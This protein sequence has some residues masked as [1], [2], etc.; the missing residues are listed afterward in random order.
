MNNPRPDSNFLQ[1]VDDGLPM[2]SAGQWAKLKLDVLGYYITLSTRAMKNKLWR[3]RFYIDLQAGPGKNLVEETGEVLLGSPILALT[4]GAG[5]SD[6]RFVEQNK[7]LAEALSKRLQSTGKFSPE[8]LIT[9]N[10]NE[11]VHHI[12]D[13]INRID[14]QYIE[15]RW[16]CLSLA[17]FDPEG[18]ELRWETVSKLAS[19]N[20]VDLIINFSTGGIR[21]YAL[22]ALEAAPGTTEMDRF[23]GNITWRNISSHSHRSIPVREWLDT[24][25]KRLEEIGFIWGTEISVPLKTTY[26]VELYRL[27][28]AS[29]HQ[30]G[31]DLW[32]ESRKRGPEQLSLF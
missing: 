14:T 17:F 28:F 12:V 25:K 5:Y 7:P 11:A 1:P 19:L 21:R 32:E 2:R 10:C 4:K 26:G 20:R 8:S 30:L 16:P 23:F 24:Y 27:L 9:A 6:Y 15:G 22:Q 3:R 31:V 29:K 18:L 13:E